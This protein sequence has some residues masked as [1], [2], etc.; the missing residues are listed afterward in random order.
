MRVAIVYCIYQGCNPTTNLRADIDPKC[1]ALHSFLPSG[2]VLSYSRPS[3][4]SRAPENAC[5]WSLSWEEFAGLFAGVEAGGHFAGSLHSIRLEGQVFHFPHDT[6][7][8]VLELAPYLG[9][10]SHISNPGMF[11]VKDLLPTSWIHTE[12][13]LSIDIR[14]IWGFGVRLGPVLWCW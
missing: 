2:Y 5:L 13:F 6:E 9:N 1:I 4:S 7:V 8:T 3:T 14:R 12:P 10:F 11:I